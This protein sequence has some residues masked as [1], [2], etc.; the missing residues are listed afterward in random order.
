MTVLNVLPWIGRQTRETEEIENRAR[1][2]RV[3]ALFDD[4]PIAPP[5]SPVLVAVAPAP[6]LVAQAPQN[7]AQEQVEE[8]VVRDRRGKITALRG[9]PD[10][11][12]DSTDERDRL[13]TEL[14]GL[15]SHQLRTPLTSIKGYAALLMDGEAGELSLDQREMLEVIRRNTDRLTALLEDVVSLSRIPSAAA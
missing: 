12:A 11:A 8:R 13:K 6:P 2:A 7:A 9:L 14:M 10:R 5:P 1:D 15:A 3:R 4:V